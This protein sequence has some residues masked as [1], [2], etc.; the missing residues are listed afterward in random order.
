VFSRL[1]PHLTWKKE[2]AYS[3]KQTIYIAPKSIIESRA[4]YASDPFYDIQSGNEAG[5]FSMGEIR[6]EGNN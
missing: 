4:H 3:N 6:K 5:L 2:Q 1:L